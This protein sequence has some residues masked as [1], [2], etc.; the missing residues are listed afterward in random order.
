MEARNFFM[1]PGASM[2]KTLI[3]I[4]PQK[5]KYEEIIVTEH[6]NPTV[7]KSFLQTYMKILRDQKAV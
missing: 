7:L 4:G 5:E 2:S 3:Q 1:D 6:S